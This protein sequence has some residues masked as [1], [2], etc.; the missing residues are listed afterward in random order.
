MI[1][2]PPLSVKK[3]CG[4]FRHQIPNALPNRDSIIAGLQSH[5]EMY[6]ANATQFPIEKRTDIRGT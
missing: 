5:R 3:E 1:R 4:K 6:T 2:I